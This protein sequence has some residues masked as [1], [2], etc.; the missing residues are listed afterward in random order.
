MATKPTMRVATSDSDL[1][2]VVDG[3]HHDPHSILGPHSSHDSVTIRALRPLA[4]AVTLVTPTVRIP[5]THEHRG[6][7]YAI[8]PGT[9]IPS[10]VLDAAY[11]GEVIPGDDP[12]RFLPTLGDVDLHLISEG[13]HE[14]L[15]N[16]LG[17]HVR[18]YDTPFGL[19]TGTSFAVW[20]P[21][22]QGVRVSGDFNFWN[23]TAHPM[24]SLGS[25]GVWELFIPNIGDGVTYVSQTHLL[26]C[27]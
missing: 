12:Y 5:M 26:A 13:R 1:D 22:A 14:E 3:W 7:W 9:G 24:R 19:V 8:V 11:D 4:D 10:Y 2:R 17:A 23:G 27:G 20:A 15:W 25:T 6:I 21:S 18:S 16:V